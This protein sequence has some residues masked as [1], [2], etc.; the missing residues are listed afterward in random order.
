MTIGEG[1]FGEG[2][3]GRAQRTGGGRA[4]RGEAK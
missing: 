4:E 2:R 3:T 1:E